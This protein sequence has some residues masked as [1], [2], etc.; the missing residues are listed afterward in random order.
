MPFLFQDIALTSFPFWNIF[1][2]QQK[3]NL[4]V[5]AKDGNYVKPV[6][7]PCKGLIGLGIWS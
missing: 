6:P 7:V 4:T 2:Y 1:L 3:Y 5:L